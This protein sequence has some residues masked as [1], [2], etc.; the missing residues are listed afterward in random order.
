MPKSIYELIPRE[1]RDRLYT[2][3]C[4][5]NKISL[6][7]IVELW[8]KLIFNKPL[9]ERDMFIMKTLVKYTVTRHGSDNFKTLAQVI[10]EVTGGE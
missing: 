3:V 6:T 9:S 5:P 10:Q 7:E 1:D 8:I 4:R 2:D